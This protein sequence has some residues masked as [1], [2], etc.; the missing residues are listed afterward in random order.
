MIKDSKI[1]IPHSKLL[2]DS[3]R[4]DKVPFVLLG[5]DAFA[6]KLYLLRQYPSQSLTPG[7]RVLTGLIEEEEY[8]K[9]CL[10]F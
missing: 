3:E 7:K 2:L 1:W 8:Q 6:R 10:E 5:D 9:I 4:L